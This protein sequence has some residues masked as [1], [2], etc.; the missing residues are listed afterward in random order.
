MSAIEYNNLLFEISQ[1]LDE[2]NVLNRLVFMCRGKLASG[3]EDNI[4]N[5]LSLFEEL[6]EHN[7]LG[8]D[9]LEEMKELLK[10][11]GE[12]SLNGKVERFE[13]KRR[14]YN[15]LLEQTIRAL[16]ELDD[17]ERLIEMCRGKISEESEDRIQDVRSL[18]KELENQN[19]L[20]AHRLDLLKGILTE[21]EKT[22]LVRE[23]EEFEERRKQEDDLKKKEDNSQRWKGICSSFMYYL[24]FFF[25]CGHRS[26]RRR[27]KASGTFK[28]FM[29]FTD[30]QKMYLASCLFR[31]N[32]LTS[33][34][35]KMLD[36]QKRKKSIYMRCTCTI[37]IA[38][39]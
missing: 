34:P 9:R 25:F 23:V 8:I 21:L 38:F 13:S 1:K 11:V 17:L 32:V 12:W 6:E 28:Q 30:K 5:V 22:D 10:G 19:N 15:V 37:S 36:L 3:S 7:N 27:I 35:K 31:D 24:F 2:L 14:E 18:F 26:S 39:N 16:D 29:C 4:Q 20:G 33:F